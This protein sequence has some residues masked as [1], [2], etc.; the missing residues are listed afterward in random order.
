MTVVSE[1]REKYDAQPNVYAIN[2]YDIMQFY[3]RQLTEGTKEYRGLNM[4]FSPNE[5]GKNTFVELREFKEWEWQKFDL[6][7]E[8][9]DSNSVLENK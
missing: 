2:G 1:F 9:K 8:Q 5:D 4:G 6:N 3:V 7:L